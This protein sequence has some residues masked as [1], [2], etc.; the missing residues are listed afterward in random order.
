MNSREKLLEREREIIRLLNFL[1]DKILISSSLEAMQLQLT[2]K[3]F[4]L[5]W[6]L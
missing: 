5:I 6:T 1:I 4:Q 3:D 2:R